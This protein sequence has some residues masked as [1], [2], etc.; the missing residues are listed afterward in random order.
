[1]HDKTLFYVHPISFL[2]LYNFLKTFKVEN[3]FKKLGLYI[4]KIYS[5]QRFIKFLFNFFFDYDF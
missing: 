5:T 3:H 4:K 2:K 1:M